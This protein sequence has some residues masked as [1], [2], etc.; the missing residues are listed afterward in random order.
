MVRFGLA[1]AAAL[2]CAPAG[3]ATYMLELIVPIYPAN[4]RAPV[5]TMFNISDAPSAVA[6]GDTIELTFTM[7]QPLPYGSLPFDAGFVGGISAG[8]V[9]FAQ[10]ANLW[11]DVTFQLGGVTGSLIT[12]GTTA[13]GNGNFGTS[14]LTIADPAT[15]TPGSSFA[16]VKLTY[17]VQAAYSGPELST[18]WFSSREVVPEPASWAMM[19]AG[20][21][22]AGAMARRRRP[23]PIRHLG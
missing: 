7:T 15:F 8:L 10:P 21:G 2:T 14:L 17:T 5:T 12:S 3:A 16:S 4:G 9:P 1:A 22:L 20:F 13:M 23:L 19:I 11:P 18:A 6:A